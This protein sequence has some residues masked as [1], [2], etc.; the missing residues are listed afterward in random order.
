MRILF[1]LQ[2]VQNESRSRGIGRYVRSLFE[3]LSARDGVELLALLNSAFPQLRS[4]S[5]RLVGEDNVL[6]WQGLQRSAGKHPGNAERARLNRYL[7]ENFLGSLDFDVLLAGS[8]FDGYDD[9]TTVS[10]KGD[11][12]YLRAAIHYDLI[13]LLNP[14]H[15]FWDGNYQPFYDE[16][17]EQLGRADILFA[18]SEATARE[19]EENLPPGNRRIVPIGAA[20][21]HR[22]FND[23]LPVN[24]KVLGAHGITKPYVM[25][26]STLE[27]RKNFDGL[28]RAFSKLPKT[29]RDKHQ[30]VFVG[31]V[32]PEY[33]KLLR[34]EATKRGLR[35]GQLVILSGLN[36]GAI[37]QLYRQAALFC[38]PSLHEGFGLPPLEAMASGCPTI[39]SDRS[40]V[41]EVIG[42]P[43]LLFNP[44][45]EEDI[46]R[47]MKRLL[48]D[49]AEA[50][51]VAQE[52]VRRASSFTW[53]QVADR[54]V[55]ALTDV[56][57][58]KRSVAPPSIIQT[59]THYSRH[60]SAPPA[61]QDAIPFASALV[62]NFDAAMA[63]RA[64]PIAS[65]PRK[66]RVEGPFDSSYSLAI[67]NRETA[68]SLEEKGYAVALRSMKEP[69]NSSIDEAYVKAQPDL[70][71]MHAQ[72]L[73]RG[74]EKDAVVSR[75]N[76]P[77][78]VEDMVGQ[79]RAL[80]HYAWEESSFPSKWVDGFNEHLTM[81]TCLSEHVRKIM[82]DSGVSVPMLVSG[83]GVDHWERITP[84]NS[85][86]V[87]ARG[88]RFLHVSSCFPR[89]GVEALLE[90]F[91]MAF[92]ASD[93][94]SLV[95]KTFDNPHNE[96]E[97]LLS[98][99]RE[100]RP[101]FPEVVTIF[102]DLTDEQL[103]ALYSQCDVMVA[104][105][106]AEG[107][108]LPLAEAML[109]GI[110]VITTSWGGQLDFCNDGNSW[111]VDYQ[112]ERARSHFNLWASAWARVDLQSLVEAMLA[113]FRASPETRAGMA[114]RGRR[115]LLAEHQWSMVT[116]RLAVAA[117][118]L[119]QVK[120]KPVRLGW[121]TT[122][123]SK[124]GIATYSAHLIEKLDCD[125]RVFAPAN[126]Q[127]LEEKDS[128]VRSWRLS[129][130][131]S[132]LTEI[133]NLRHAQDI[134]VFVIQFNYGFYN[135][136]DLGNFIH[137]ARQAGKKVLLFLHATNHPGDQF[138]PGAEAF[139]LRYMVPALRACD[140]LLVHSID[141]LNRLKALGL[142]ENVSLFPHGALQLDPGPDKKTGSKS[143]RTVGTYG[144]A[145]PHKGLSETI[146]AVHLLRSRGHDIRLKMTNA[147]YPAQVS[148][149]YV[150]ELRK[151]IADLRLEDAV[152][153]N[154]DFLSDEQTSARLRATDL[155]VFPYQNTEESASGAVRYGMAMH[156][157]VMVSPNPIFKDLGGATFQ[158]AA[159]TADD[160]A[161]GILE[162]FSEIDAKS[163]KASQIAANAASWRDEHSYE[164]LGRRLSAMC[165]AL[166]NQY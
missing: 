113:A 66:W 6:V 133:F 114:A 131:N 41:P 73:S 78:L 83:C 105:S 120:R 35:D 161:D 14:D 142:V 25:H 9:D 44:D 57:L 65:A 144:F 43:E 1:D 140:R 99:W 4:E 123:N 119:P 97:R 156:K 70:A 155:I 23:K 11:G 26:L 3:A 130:D 5:A 33:A 153:F 107:Y 112:F 15:F 94:V 109:S 76:Y 8:M 84:D 72:F 103:K 59:I 96:V 148:L 62:A 141:D 108:G 137:Q 38:F 56:A 68:R 146:Q 98:E 163:E 64:R 143:R 147:Q 55:E 79:V 136:G 61:E 50:S 82:I 93:D 134:D 115:Q 91:G 60:A 49:R 69:G 21:D 32:N 13:P 47:A 80:H 74:I 125:V 149:D 71:R 54:L 18:I 157:P 37:A 27:P 58:P 127:T 12:Q 63:F 40:S 77:P 46:A 10:L 166:A 110:P 152:D 160:I 39:G 86:R 100:K 118:A 101:D 129:K 19:A 22:A 124:C 88:F 106:F 162:A 45:D 28:I 81:M 89:K 17:L 122:W 92:S 150:A 165:Q 2:A 36:D 111:L 158:C 116:D 85:Y 48:S 31:T 29:I 138:A 75:N 121:I 7:Y 87:E 154:S 30:L 51:R 117:Q 139:H 95:I 159:A 24:R 20:I 53:S 52:G 34:V 164:N 16:R 102:G 145:L 126:E 132:F 67:L 90:A 42:D 104:P 151:L 128:S 135:H